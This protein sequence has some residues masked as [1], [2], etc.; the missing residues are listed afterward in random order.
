LTTDTHFPWPGWRGAWRAD[1]HVR[2]G[3][4]DRRAPVRA[5]QSP[6]TSTKTQPPPR[7]PLGEPVVPSQPLCD[8]PPNVTPAVAAF[9]LSAAPARA[10]LIPSHLLDVAS[11]SGDPAQGRPAFGTVQPQQIPAFAQP[12]VWPALRHTCERTLR[13][14]TTGGR[15][16][17]RPPVRRGQRPASASGKQP[18]CGASYRLRGP[19]A[20]GWGSN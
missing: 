15:G 12:S 16:G 3:N 1:P 18:P 17:N 5:L 13:S 6:L 11:F 9:E 2:A 4:R 14:Q 7:S 8:R 20:P 10:L 19:A